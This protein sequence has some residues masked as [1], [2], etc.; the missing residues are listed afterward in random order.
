MAGV[1]LPVSG[2]HSPE[3][4][5]HSPIL[6]LKN[7]YYSKT[8][9][10][11]T[12]TIYPM[13]SLA[14][15]KSFLEPKELAIAGV[16]RNP[17]K[18]GRV[19]YDT[20]KD[21]GFKLYPVHPYSDEIA[22]DACVKEITE[23]PDHVKRLYIVTGKDHT[24]ELVEQAAKKGIKEIWIQQTSDTPESIEI[25]EKNDITLIHKQCIMK[26]AEPVKGIHKFHRSISKLFGTFPK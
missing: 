26:F 20:L 11:E 6:D 13:T 4:K 5:R 10:S 16:S 15:I 24:T 2:Q 14:T 12:I 8:C 22:G 18:F 7:P 19:V 25:A 3:I 9:G 21:R 23:L 17:K 1:F